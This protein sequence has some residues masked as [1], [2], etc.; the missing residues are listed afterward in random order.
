[1]LTISDFTLNLHT[2]SE[3]DEITIVEHWKT[4]D[5]YFEHS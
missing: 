1:M 5:T 3:E 4:D 2:R